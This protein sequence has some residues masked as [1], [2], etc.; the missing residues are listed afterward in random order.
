MGGLPL[1]QGPYGA[2]GFVAP[3]LPF[4]TK[5]P[6][7]ETYYGLSKG[8]NSIFVDYHYKMSFELEG[9]ETGLG[10]V[11]TARH[12]SEAIRQAFGAH[13]RRTTFTTTRATK[14]N[15]FEQQILCAGLRGQI[16]INWHQELGRRPDEAERFT[17]FL[18]GLKLR[19]KRRLTSNPSGHVP[20]PGGPI[21]SNR[22][23]R[24]TFP[25]W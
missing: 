8:E 2:G 5:G 3:V 15:E 7:L 16:E 6:R 25:W 13:T 21:P 22:G 4:R 1:V 24:A 17:R 10:R 14:W 23:Q 19:S 18:T 20:G 11:N 9:N 12:L